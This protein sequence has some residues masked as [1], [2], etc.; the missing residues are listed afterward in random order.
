MTESVV[1]YDE[2]IGHQNVVSWIKSNVARDNIPQ[3]II[4]HG[5]SGIGKS[6]LAKLLA[7]DVTTM[8][9]EQSMREEYIQHVIRENVSTDSIKLFNMSEIQ[10]KEE[11]IQKVKAEF[12]L[13]FSKTKRKAILLDEAHNMSAKAQDSILVDLEH[14]PKGI[15]VFIC[16]TELERLRTALQSRAVPIGLNNLTDAECR[17]LIKREIVAKNLRFE[18][19]QNMAIAYIA[20]WADNQ[21]RKALNLL[22]GFKAGSVITSKELEVF[23]SVDAAAQILQLLEYIYGPMALGITYIEN[24]KVDRT[25]VDMLL[26][27]TKVA[28]GVDSASISPSDTR[29]IRGFM[30]DKDIDNLLKFT[31][32]VAGLKYLY[33]HNIISAFM[34]ANVQYT[35]NVPPAIDKSQ[36]F[37]Q[38]DLQFLAE[39]V[40][41]V[42]LTNER[43][44][45]LRVES[46]DELF[47]RAKEILEE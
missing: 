41:A 30:H 40:E 33:K 36:E 15:Y 4:F 17:R 18:I 31:A 14:L 46:L 12:V 10:E 11:E 24:L 44:V 26:E 38:K 13:G 28:L 3:V 25:F 34:R 47:K 32:E 42:Q 23:I 20:S 16:T 45:D 8:Y 27:V 1:T 6:A 7:V 21:P 22:E 5:N 43:D 2:I 37:K 35:K 29:N 9:A 39:N 19:S